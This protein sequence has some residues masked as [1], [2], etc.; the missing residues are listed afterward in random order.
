MTSNVFSRLMPTGQGRSFYEELRGQ[1]DTLDVE[2]RAG[3]LDEE[4]L[5]HHFH[6]DDLENAE[7]LGVDDSRINMDTRASRGKSGRRYPAAGRSNRKVSAGWNVHDDDGDNDVPASLL[8]ERHDG[9]IPDGTRQ[10]GRHQTDQDTGHI[11]GSSKARVQWETAQMQQQLHNDDLFNSSRHGGN[12]PN[13]FLAGVISGNAKKKAEWRWANVSNLD[14]F[15]KNV[16]DYYQG[17]GAWC[18][19]IERILHLM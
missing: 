4:N 10:P 6:D 15:I 5:N 2:D 3:L 17:C 13:V 14:T 7:G 19:I 18:I 8:V 9:P 12:A 1:Q 16:Y 11:P